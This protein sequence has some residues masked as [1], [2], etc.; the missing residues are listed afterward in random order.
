VKAGSRQGMK[1]LQIIHTQGHGGAEN[2]FRWLAWRIRREGINVVAGIPEKNGSAKEYWIG[3]ALEELNVPYVTFDKNGSGLNL[4]KSIKRLIENVQPDIVHSHLLDSNF[5]SALACRRLSMPHICTEHGDIALKTMLSHALKYYLLPVFTDSVVCVSKAVRQRAARLPYQRKFSVIYNGIVPGKETDSTF[6]RELGLSHDAVLI[7]NV[8]N[9]YPVKG[10]RY[11]IEAF[12]RCA[13]LFPRAYLILVGRGSERQEL[14]AQARRLEIPAGRI[15]FT[16][17]RSDVVN[18]LRSLDL[19]VQP[20]LSEGLPVSLLEAV[21]HQIPVVATAVGGVPEVLAEGE[22]GILVAPGSSAEL[23]GAIKKV[24]ENL[25]VYKIRAKA[26]RRLVEEKFSL[27]SM[28]RQYIEL[29]D[30]TLGMQ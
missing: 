21:W 15:V 3:P 27:D 17:F 7:G 1:V 23:E 12:S 9:L 13:A 5:Y 22:H 19:Y 30:K 11:L 10:Q 18:I 25:A 24:V 28:A 4:L 20:S 2:I 26:A 29:Y 14:E 16:G 6:R 8:G